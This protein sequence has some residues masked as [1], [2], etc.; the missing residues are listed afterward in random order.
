[1]EGLVTVPPEH[2]RLSPN[3]LVLFPQPGF[4]APYMLVKRKLEDTDGE[5]YISEYG[6]ILLRINT[7]V[8]GKINLVRNKVLSGKYDSNRQVNWTFLD[9]PEIDEY[10][11]IDLFSDRVFP[12]QAFVRD[13]FVKLDGITFINSEYLPD[14][15]EEEGYL[16]SP[17]GVGGKVLHAG[18]SLIVSEDLRQ[19][20]L[21]RRHL[22]MLKT[23]GY[24]IGYIPHVRT[25]R[26]PEGKRNF[27]EDH[28]DGHSNLIRDNKGKTYF[29]YS[30]SYARQG[31]KAARELRQAA[32]FAKAV[33]IE[34]DD[35]DLPFLAFNFLQLR[36]GTVILSA[37]S[38][39][40]G[41][42]KLRSRLESVLIEILGKDKVVTT[43]IPITRISS[44]LG[45]SIRCLTNIG[46][47][48]LIA[49]ILGQ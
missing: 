37:T 11:T 18:R 22:E 32:D 43:E 33:D 19:N 44:D 26:Q 1:M 10:P 49:K 12:G 23:K 20:P 42:T 13:L 8:N 21:A 17:L 24:K 15:K 46:T 29:L 31:G 40:N 2:L 45:G 47:S 4:L 6:A 25:E 9:T 48:Q 39:Q 27:V 3:E 5:E 38:A 7:L 36:D 14:F 34:I 16:H 28:I 41:Q 30:K 35:K